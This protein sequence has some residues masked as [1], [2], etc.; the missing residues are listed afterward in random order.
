MLAA[1]FVNALAGGFLDH[2]EAQFKISAK[3]SYFTRNIV[4]NQRDDLLAELF[5]VET[6]CHTRHRLCRRSA[7][8]VIDSR[9]NG[10][11]IVAQSHGAEKSDRSQCLVCHID[12][13][14]LDGDSVNP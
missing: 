5:A 1:V 9:Q 12:V 3:F 4:L 10:N 11:E 7:A 6:L 2:L 14:P 13:R 8:A